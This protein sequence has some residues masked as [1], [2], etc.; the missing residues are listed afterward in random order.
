MKDTM[1]INDVMR[2]LPHRYPFLLIDKVIE[3]NDGKSLVAVKNV[4]ITEPWFM[5]HFPAEPVMPGVLILEALAQAAGILAYRSFGQSP[6]KSL[7]LLGSIQHARFKQVV[8][9]GDQL[10]L[11]ITFVG[12]KGHFCKVEA[13]AEVDGQVVCTADIMSAR[14]DIAP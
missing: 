5:G 6:E 14:K 3:Y 4:T 10:L 1:D 8:R 9:P 12:S 11:H 13:R 2:L 7:Y